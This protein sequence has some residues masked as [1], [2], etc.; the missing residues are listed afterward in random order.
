MR[1][2]KGWLL[3]SKSADNAVYQLFSFLKK[4]KAMVYNKTAERFSPTD[5]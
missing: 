5:C 2:A 4:K 3:Q 1:T